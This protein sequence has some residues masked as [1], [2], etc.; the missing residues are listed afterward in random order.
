[1]NEKGK[2]AARLGRKATGPQWVAGLPNTI[3]LPGRL[4]RGARQNS[5]SASDREAFGRGNPSLPDDWT[6]LRPGP[7]YRAQPAGLRSHPIRNMNSPLHK[8][9]AH[10]KPRRLAAGSKR[11]ACRKGKETRARQGARSESRRQRL[12]N[13]G[14][15]PSRGVQVAFGEGPLRSVPATIFALSRRWGTTVRRASR[16]GG[17]PPRV[18]RGSVVAFEPHTRDGA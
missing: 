9:Q 17:I 11:R 1:M 18:A 14:P 15:C 12:G 13:L 3:G 8:T 2:P 10:Q 4:I 5:G 6:R 7:P 16:C